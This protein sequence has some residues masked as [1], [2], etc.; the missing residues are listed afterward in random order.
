VT[1]EG[2]GVLVVGAASAHGRAVALLAAARGAAVVFSVPPG[3]EARAA[4]IEGLAAGR[5]GS[6]TADATREDEAERLFGAAL[7]RLPRVDVVVSA[8]PDLPAQR[9]AETSL[10]E[11]EG[12]VARSLRGA[13][14]VSRL[15]VEEF[16]AHGA[17]GR[18]VHVT[19][20]VRPG[21]PAQALAAVTLQALLSLMRSTAKEYGPRRVACNAVVPV[22][23]DAEGPGGGPPRDAV[24]EA[25]LFLASPEA[26]YVNGEAIR[27][28]CSLP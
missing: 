4:E 3:E 13:F 22:P 21:A 11:W 10:A 17:G 1:L 24:A 7:G 12:A 8:T 23:L 14:F 26:S 28:S 19:P 27:A 9:L 18:L 15:A 2:R 25:V 20:R 6:V 16:L 5:A